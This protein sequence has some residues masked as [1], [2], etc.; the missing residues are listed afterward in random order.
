[1]IQAE[2]LCKTI[3][4]QPVLNHISLKI[5]R[6]EIVSVIGP[7]GAGKT[8]LLRAL[9]L[10]EPPDLGCLS[11]D[12]H[13]Y[14]FPLGPHDSLRPPYPLMTAVFQQLFIWPHLTMRDNILL[15]VQKRGW[16][17]RYFDHLVTLFNMGTFLH[18]YPNQA[19]IGERQRAALVRA[20]LLK[21]S[22]L[23][24]D[25]VTSALDIEQSLL[26]VDH[27]RDIAQEGIG[28]FLISHAIHLAKRV[29]DRVIFMEKGAIVETG[30][31]DILS[32]PSTDRLSL[33][34]SQSV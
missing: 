25:E 28:L 17:H 33:F 22:Y 11:I 18:R 3:Q 19:S 27:L 4:N 9:T 26:I 21:P 7:S 23:F 29:S 34:L 13:H 30:S 32:H 1:M 16:D 24:L 15:P 10:I 14:R 8:T 12:A 2:D 20:L 5:G 31:P 6:G